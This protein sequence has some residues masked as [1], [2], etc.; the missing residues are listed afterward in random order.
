MN[1]FK[2]RKHFKPFEYPEV[3]QYIDA[4]NHSY[5][6]HSELNFISDTQ[7]FRTNL[8][9]SQK[10]IIHKALLAISQI[11][12]KVKGFW[13]DLYKHV[14]KPEVN[15]VGVTFAES[16]V[17]HERAYSHLIEVLGLNDDFEQVMEVPEIKGRVEYLSKY[18]AKEYKDD[19]RQFTLS[20]ILF[21]I[22]VENVSLFSQFV[23]IMSF[24]KH[25]GILKDISNV[26]E[27]TSKEELLHGQF[28][29]YL[30]NKIKEENPEWFTEAF[31]KK[32]TDAAE[33]AFTAE[34]GIIDWIF[35]SGELEF[36]PADTVKEFI[37]DRINGSLVSI[38]A[39]EL[40]SIDEEKLLGI[41]WFNE[42]IYSNSLT[43]FFYKRPT[44]Y[45][46]RTQP[47]T[48]NDLF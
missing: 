27:W 9:S 31:Y 42:E 22:F 7:D 24:N 5:W 16:E 30:V 25:K 19:K 38:G 26:V 3:I 44:S 40:Y 6:L 21:S 10:D 43:D 48:E 15:A 20:L 29:I 33:K 8:D 32:I 4:I 37:K 46:K 2:E 34:C 28:G 41:A 35:S 14:P 11:E 17:R 36:L 47:I 45:A 39:K 1:I 12:V 18:L 13:G 23:I